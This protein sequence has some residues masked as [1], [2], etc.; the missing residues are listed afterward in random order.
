MRQS[1][2]RLNDVLRVALH[3]PFVVQQ[4]TGIARHIFGLLRGLAQ[5][6]APDVEYVCFWPPQAPWPDFLP[7]NFRPEPL[8]IAGGNPISRVL[9]E[10]RWMR[11]VHR[12]CPF[13]VIHS[14]F[15]YLPPRPPA[16]SV[17]TIHDCRWLRY[18]ETFSLLRGRFLRW[19]MPMSVR[20]ARVTLA[21]SDA[22]RQES[23][24]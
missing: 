11:A 24:P 20:Q 13:D 1:P 12:R 19:A 5:V 18:P 22:T 2:A 16:P 7:A 17:V 3:T 8:T 21:L 6:A 23:S 4:N 10:A 9:R 15:G 14:P